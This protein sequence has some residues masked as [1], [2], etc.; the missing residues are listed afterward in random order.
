MNVAFLTSGGIAPCLSSS[1]ARMIYTYS[2]LNKDI[3]FIGYLHGYKGLLTNKKIIISQKAISNINIL[4]D[5]GGTFLGNSRVKLTNIDDCI[6]NRYIKE[7][8]NPLVVAASQL[9]SD[10][11]DIL[12][13]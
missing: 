13:S 11:I 8:E 10:N 9:I 6:S 12:H 1:I 2:K 5:Y 4:Y 7:G 3:K